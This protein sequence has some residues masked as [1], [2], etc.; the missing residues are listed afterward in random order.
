M[1]SRDVL[2]NITAGQAIYNSQEEAVDNIKNE[3]AKDYPKY[4]Q[5][6]FEY[7]VYQYDLNKKWYIETKIFKKI[8]PYKDDYT[9]EI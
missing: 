7:N 6:T 2:L 3:I 5:Y 8:N 9:I 4:N 1:S